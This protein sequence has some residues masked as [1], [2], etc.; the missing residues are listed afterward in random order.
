MDRR[1]E[2]QTDRHADIIHTYRETDTQT[3]RQTG[4][5]VGRHIDIHKDRNKGRHT[6][7]Q[8]G[9]RDSDIHVK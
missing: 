1:T 6:D 4:R 7:G 2:G 8:I 3:G 9:L 5:H